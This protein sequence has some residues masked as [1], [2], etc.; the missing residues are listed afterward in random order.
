LCDKPVLPGLK[1]ERTGR[2]TMTRCGGV[3]EIAVRETLNCLSV[4]KRI[5]EGGVAQSN[6]II[7]LSTRGDLH[8]A[9]TSPEFDCYRSRTGSSQGL[10]AAASGGP[11]IPGIIGRAVQVIIH[12]CQFFGGK[13]GP[14]TLLGAAHV[15]PEKYDVPAS[16]GP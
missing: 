11:G 5:G 8:R 13:L 2:Q 15:F 6:G 16:H 9:V 1:S 10:S 14:G 12:I 4:L 3:R 7:H